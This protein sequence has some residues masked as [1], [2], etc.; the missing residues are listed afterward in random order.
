[1]LD[2]ITATTT[3]TTISRDM[4]ATTTP[5]T[6]TTIK[7]T[8]TNTTTK[9]WNIYEKHRNATYSNSKKTTKTLQQVQ[10]YQHSTSTATITKTVY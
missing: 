2:I 7:S 4:T 9:H 6:T 5:T 3:K 8:T 10:T 1:M